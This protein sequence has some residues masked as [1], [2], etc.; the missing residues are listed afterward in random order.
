MLMQNIDILKRLINIV[1]TFHPN[2]YKLEEGLDAFIIYK[3]D[4]VYFKD[5]TKNEDAH[6]KVILMLTYDLWQTSNFTN[7]SIDYIYSLIGKD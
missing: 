4:R 6:L 7:M 5:N 1:N 3:Y 2:K